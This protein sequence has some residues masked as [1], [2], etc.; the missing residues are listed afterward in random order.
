MPDYSWIKP[1][2]KAIV[3]YSLGDSSN[4]NPSADSLDG[5][6]LLIEGFPHYDEDCNGYYYVF[7]S[8]AEPYRGCACIYLKPYHEDDK[9]TEYWE[10]M[11][12]PN[13][14]PEI[15]KRDTKELEPAI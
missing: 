10:E 15:E 12:D 7:A 14:L 3:D 2:V 5:R 4:M 8:G 6:V 9:P 11:M 13:K 1:G